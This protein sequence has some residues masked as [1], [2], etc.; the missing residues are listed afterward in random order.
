MECH[1]CHAGRQDPV[2]CVM[3]CHDLYAAGAYPAACS[4]M[5]RLHSLRFRRLLVF[6]TSPSSRSFSVPSA[7][8]LAPPC[9]GT[10]FRAYRAFPRVSRA[11]ALAP[12]RARIAAARFARLIAQARARAR[13]PKRRAHLSRWLPMGFFAPAQKAKRSG[14]AD[15]A[16]FLLSDISM[17]TPESTHPGE[18]LR[19]FQEQAM[20]SIHWPTPHPPGPGFQYGR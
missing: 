10:L 5:G 4:G 12:G 16:S 13:E 2:Q 19:I 15:A 3:G 18:L 6:G 14:P 11:G 20:A 7:P 9:G 8:P 1:V 17:G